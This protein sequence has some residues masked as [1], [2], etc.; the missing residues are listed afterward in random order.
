MR[1]LALA[2]LSLPLL[3][4][5]L[6]VKDLR[7]EVGRGSVS[8]YDAEYDYDAGPDSALPSGTYTADEYEGTAPVAVS[9][10]WSRGN[11]KPWGFIWAA[12]GEWQHS[13]DDALGLTFDTDVFM[14]KG[15]AG[16]GWCPG[17]R[18]RLEATAELAVG[19]IRVEDADVDTNGDVWRE[20]ATGSYTHIGAQVGAAWITNKGVEFGVSF[21]ALACAAY[22]EAEFD[23]TGG[24]YEADV[25]WVLLTGAL[26]VGYRF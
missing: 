18:W 14:A 10:L 23:Q 12:G 5:D 21:R 13:E 3:A 22:T 20:D 24:G 11:L 26:T 7:L 1:T 4:A 17:E 19:Y 2:L 15:R 6:Q 16:V 9:L 25:T 8:S